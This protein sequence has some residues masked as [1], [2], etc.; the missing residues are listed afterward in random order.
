MA[1]TNRQIRTQA[2]FGNKRTSFGLALA[3][4]TVV[5]TVKIATTARTI[6]KYLM[7]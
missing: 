6:S 3:A 7:A 4:K 1:G 5:K 2:H